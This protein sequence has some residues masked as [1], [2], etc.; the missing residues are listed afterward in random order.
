MTDI[1]TN[2]IYRYCKRNENL[3]DNPVVCKYKSNRHKYHEP[4]NHDPDIFCKPGDKYIY[5]NKFYEEYCSALNNINKN[6]NFKLECKEHHSERNNQGIFLN[7]TFQLKSDQFGFSYLDKQD[8]PKNHPY[9]PYN[10]YLYGINEDDLNKALDNVEDWK[11]KTR[12]VGGSFLWPIEE[13][14]KT[15]NPIYNVRRGGNCNYKKSFSFKGNHYIQ[16]RVDLTLFEIKE[17]YAQYKINKKVD[18]KNIL[19]KCLKKNNSKLYEFLS[20]FGIGEEGFKS[21][22]KFFA[23]DDFV[24]ESNGEHKIVDIY[25]SELFEDCSK[26]IKKYVNNRVQDI[27]KSNGEINDRSCNDGI[28]KETTEDDFIRMFNNICILIQRRRK[29]LGLEKRI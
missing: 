23:F 28:H 6:S 19:I 10:V 16:D 22:I 15:Y 17:F 4:N 18:N 5:D 27:R 25:K 24:S 8:K 1:Y 11:T 13:N 3:K 12:I 2:S 20:L 26:D 29:R 14:D 9:H 7:N 21:Y